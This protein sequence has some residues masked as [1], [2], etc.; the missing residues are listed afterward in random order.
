MLKNIAKTLIEK[1]TIEKEEY[2]NILKGKVA[3]K[4]LPEKSERQAKLKLR[5]I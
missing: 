1:E 2:E 4:K 5:H 3:V